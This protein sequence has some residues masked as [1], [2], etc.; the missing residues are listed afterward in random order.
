MIRFVA[1]FIGETNVIPATV[2]KPAPDTA[3]CTFDGGVVPATNAQAFRTGAR[4]ALIVRPE[5]VCISARGGD[6]PA[7]YAGGRI[8]VPV[9]T[10]TL[11]ARR[12]VA[13]G[14]VRQQPAAR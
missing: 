7:G 2:E 6:L 14:P 9:L 10:F 11:T 1:E 8:P 13:E 12:S 5:H 3:R 4:V